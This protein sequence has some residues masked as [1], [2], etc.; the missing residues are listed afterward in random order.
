MQDVRWLQLRRSLLDRGWRWRANTLY[1]P[2]ETMW[3]T[4]TDDQASVTA[5]RDQVTM[6]ADADAEAEAEAEAAY[7]ALD[8]DRAALQQDL[9]SL[10]EALDDVLDN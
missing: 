5:F 10:V 3:F 9:V 8:V 7:V 2:H 6:A 1:A 4:T